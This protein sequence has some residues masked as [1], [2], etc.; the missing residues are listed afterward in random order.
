[1]GT[2]KENYEAMKKA[3]KEERFKDVQKIK[4]AI[5]ASKKEIA[6]VQGP[7]IQKA[8]KKLKAAKANLSNMKLVVENNAKI[9]KEAG[10]LEKTEKIVANK[11][12]L[13]EK[14]K[15]LAVVQD[16][17]N[18]AVIKESEK[19][20]KKRVRVMAR[21]DKKYASLSCNSIQLK[22]KKLEAR[23]ETEK[24]SKDDNK[25]ALV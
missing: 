19:A 25:Q 22:I 12:M 7:L 21:L 18:K 15:A 1:M 9:K 3:I 4:V 20:F 16:K 6:D 24:K 2:L 11:M 13:R 23:L 8:L 10:D 14:E 5:V 17:V